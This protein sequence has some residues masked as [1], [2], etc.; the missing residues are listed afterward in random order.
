MM[1][2]VSFSAAV[3]TSFLLL[4]LAMISCSRCCSAVSVDSP[5]AGRVKKCLDAS[6]PLVGRAN[7]ED[8]DAYEALFPV[9]GSEATGSPRDVPVRFINREKI[10]GGVEVRWVRS[11]ENEILLPSV[12]LGEAAGDSA[13][14]RA[15]S[16]Q[17]FRVYAKAERKLIAEYVADDE[18]CGE[19]GMHA[20]YLHDCEEPSDKE[21]YYVRPI[22]KIKSFERSEIGKVDLVKRPKMPVLLRNWLSDEEVSHFTDAAIEEHLGEEQVVLFQYSDEMCPRNDEAGAVSP[23]ELGVRFHPTFNATVRVRDIM[24]NSIEAYFPGEKGSQF[25]IKVSLNDPESRASRRFFEYFSSHLKT[26][27]KVHT[28]HDHLLTDSAQLDPTIRLTVPGYFTYP[29]HFDCIEVMLHQLRGRKRV[30]LIEPKYVKRLTSELEHSQEIFHCSGYRDGIS[31]NQTCVPAKKKAR[32]SRKGVIWEAVLEPGDALWLP[33][34]W[35]HSVETIGHNNSHGISQPFL[36]YNVDPLYDPNVDRSQIP[37][38]VAMY[39]QDQMA[40]SR[41][42]DLFYPRQTQ[43]LGQENTVHEGLDHN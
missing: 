29:W 4:L 40:C 34:Q 24:R 6:I 37:H 20:V 8:I 26:D 2:S 10:K 3:R 41:T 17:A 33:L 23:G 5:A 14:Y 7:P 11:Y 16:G 30:L 25:Q 18:Q 12:K 19:D 31:A 22:R 43:V 21:E 1:F 28:I 15:F 38:N 35:H 39:N 42:F 9:P 36:L 32:S 13:T 27:E